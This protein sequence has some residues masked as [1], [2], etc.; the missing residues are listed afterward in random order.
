MHTPSTHTRDRSGKDR[1]N[2]T[3]ES[4]PDGDMLAGIRLGLSRVSRLLEPTPQSWPAIHVAGTNGKGS[5]SSYIRAMLQR[6]GKRTGSF[7]S[8][9]VVDRWDCIRIN[10][11]VIS[12][13]LFQTI[14]ADVLAWNEKEK[15]RGSSFELLTA[16]AYR[17]FTAANVDIAVVECGM[18]GRFDATNVLENSVATAITSIGLDHQDFLGRSIEEIAWH[19]AGIMKKDVPCTILPSIDPRAKKT[20]EDEALSVGVSLPS[21]LITI[22]DFRTQARSRDCLPQAPSI[23]FSIKANHR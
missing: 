13:S 12:R 10:D 3:P 20:I 18:G 17:A 5:V 23:L 15:I 6:S 2:D 21:F 22:P 4:Q 1:R 11:E 9:H 14:E 16:I 19:K 7:N 8:P